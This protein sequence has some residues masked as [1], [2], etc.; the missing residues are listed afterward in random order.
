MFDVIPNVKPRKTFFFNKNRDLPQA[1]LTENKDRYYSL[2]QK[3]TTHC[4]ER[5]KYNELQFNTIRL[6]LVGR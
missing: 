1:T 2:I 4:N 5:V 3:F 6:V